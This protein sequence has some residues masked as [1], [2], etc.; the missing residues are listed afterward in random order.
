MP[1]VVIED[2]NGNDAASFMDQAVENFSAV[3]RVS[4]E[5]VYADASSLIAHAVFRI[6]RSDMGAASLNVELSLSQADTY[7]EIVDATTVITSGQTEKE[8]ILS[9]DYAGNTSGDL[10]VTV[11]EGAG[12]APAIAPND[13]ATV[14]VKA[15]VAG[16][17]LA[18]VHDQADWTVDEGDNARLTMTLTLADGLA[19]PRDNF[20][21]FID[22]EGSSANAQQTGDPGD[23]KIP[24]SGAQ[25]PVLADRWTAR[26]GGGFT[27]TVTLEVETV[28]DAEPEGEEVFRA[29]F[30]VSNENGAIE[31]PALPDPNVDPD[32][33]E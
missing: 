17:P 3:P 7:L 18:V 10:T 32:A 4:I 16:K 28:E 22:L 30:N 1:T 25:T 8:L 2:A 29:V 13:A 14:E 12:H 11:A 27:Q 15:P 21:L 5:R 24:V 31:Y 20:N 23:F 6:R 9:L 26:T 19:D 33:P